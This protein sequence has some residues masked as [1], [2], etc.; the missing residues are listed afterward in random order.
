MMGRHWNGHTT[1]KTLA[2][3]LLG[4]EPHHVHKRLR[5]HGL[6]SLVPRRLVTPNGT[7]GSEDVPRMQGLSGGVQTP[8]ALA[9]SGRYLQLMTGH[10][11]SLA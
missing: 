4:L 10:T 3:S 1:N 7:D 5:R 8:I 2:A 6:G 11:V 9:Q